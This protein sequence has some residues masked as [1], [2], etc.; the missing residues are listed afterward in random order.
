MLKFGIAKNDSLFCHWCKE[1]IPYGEHYVA[2]FFSVKWGERKVRKSF[3]FHVDPCY[4]EWKVASFNDKYSYW[5]TSL[6]EPKKRGRPKTYQN[7]K[8]IHRMKSL[9]TYHRKA[10]NLDKV[11]ELEEQLA[12]IT[13]GT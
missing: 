13:I 10:G 12:K 7:G 2:L 1:N 9:I 5:K 3:I 8:E 6:T 4:I 11:G